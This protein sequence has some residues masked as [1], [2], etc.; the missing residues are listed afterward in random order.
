MIASQY[1]SGLVIPVVSY[2]QGMNHLSL[3]EFSNQF[4]HF[5]RFG[6]AACLEF[7]VDQLPV[8]TD[9]VPAAIGRDESHAFDL[10]F[11]MLE[12][13]VRQANGPVSVM[14]DL[15]IND[16]DFHHRAISLSD[17]PKIILL[18]A[19]NRTFFFCPANE[20]PVF[21]IVRHLTHGFPA[22]IIILNIIPREYY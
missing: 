1:L 2:G 7:G 13:I 5:T 17:N 3:G 6:M 11:E 4:Y 14:S 10:R 12:Q 19:K 18:L 16:L 9:F 20:I 8:D 21:T 22:C 15:A